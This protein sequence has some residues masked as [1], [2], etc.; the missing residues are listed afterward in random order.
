MDIK[1]TKETKNVKIVKEHSIS[2]ENIES[3]GGNHEF[4]FRSVEE[5]FKVHLLFPYGKD[6]WSKKPKKEI[7]DT[8]C[9]KEEVL[10]L[11]LKEFIS[12]DAGMNEVIVSLTLDD[13]KN[14]GKDI[15]IMEG[16]FLDE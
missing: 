1:L 10:F 12:F 4:V 11:I 9:V 16:E 3:E 8:L 14:V 7:L 13:Y 2:I 6:K 15:D 5:N